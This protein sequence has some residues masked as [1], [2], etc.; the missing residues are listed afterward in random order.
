MSDTSFA[1]YVHYGTNAQ[2]LAF[3]PSPGGGQPLYAWYETDTGNLYVYDTSWHLVVASTGLTALTGQVTAS[4]SGSVVATINKPYIPFFTNQLRLTTESGVP[5][6]ITDRITQSTIYL[7]PYLG[8]Q[9]GLYSGS[10]WIMFNQA[11]ISL[12]LSGLTSGKNYDVFCDYNSGTPQLV[13]SAAWA[14]DIARADALARQDGVWVKSGTTTYRWLG[15]IRTTGTTTTED[16]GG[17]TGTTQVGGKR[18]VWNAYNQVPRSNQVIDTVDS[19]PYTTNTIRQA[20]AGA[21]AGNKVEYVTGDAASL[22]DA[23]VR[24]TVN[25]QANTQY[26]SA[27]VGVDS[28]TTYSGLRNEVFMQSTTQAVDAAIGGTYKG[29]PGLGY[30]YIAW[31][32]KGAAGTACS[33]LGDNGAS[34]QSGLVVEMWN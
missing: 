18:F 2:R 33:F 15:T 13:L 1:A 5:V 24:A 34:A 7:T 11:E 25:I 28:I 26:A 12:A 16:S 29:Y 31:N 4:G 10:A 27:G 6:S 8:N 14:S 19:W 23:E 22:I 9:I 32:E 20:N 21:G 30:H 17:I 3:T